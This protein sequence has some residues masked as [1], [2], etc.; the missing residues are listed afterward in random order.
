M[1]IKNVKWLDISY[2]VIGQGEP[3]PI[4]PG[5]RFSKDAA[6]VRE[7]ATD[8]AREGK[9]GLIWDRPNTGASEDCF[10]GESRVD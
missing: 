10:A 6:G 7:M 4:I 1:P 8:L 2:E 3:W 5:G 9:E